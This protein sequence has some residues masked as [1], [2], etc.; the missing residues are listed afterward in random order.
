MDIP[1]EIDDITGVAKAEIVLGYDANF[2]EVQ[3]VSGADLIE[4]LALTAKTDVAGK[5]AI[6]LTGGKG[7]A[8]GSGVM[9]HVTLK[10]AKDAPVGETEIKFEKNTLFDEA[11]KEIPSTGTNGK[12]NVTEYQPPPE[13]PRWDVNQD[14]VVDIADLVLV[15]IHFG[16]DYRNISAIA[17]QG[18]G[19]LSTNPAI[20]VKLEANGKVDA[21]R[22]L[23]VDV[24][25][26]DAIDLYGYQLGLIFDPKALKV[27]GAAP[28]NLLEQ[29]GH[30]T[31]L[32]RRCYWS[33]SGIDNELGH[34]REII[35]VRK[36]VKNGVSASGTLATITFAVKDVSVADSTRLSLV[37]VA[38]ADSSARKVKTIHSEL[39]L[40]WERLLIP[41]KSGLLQ[42]YPNPFNPETW[43]PYCLSQTADVTIR[44]YDLKGQ[45]V[46]AFHIGSRPAGWYVSKT[47]A[48]YWN[49]RNESGEQVASGV[50]FYQLQADTLSDMEKLL[51]VR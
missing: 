24:I 46:R 36:A 31:A 20:H 30:A 14:G 32:R 11:G 38:M 37:N 19:G 8:G 1:V 28:G 21:W 50:Y 17:A 45:L 39:E 22:T 3:D 47:K 7:L 49:G 6:S 29:D 44:I 34:I 48:T 15:G 5:L 16:E 25:A 10:I 13:Y 35:Q 26:E 51:V 12:L 18:D 42:N 4:G 23:Q 43:I 40:H 9:F 41:Q 27:I 2:L 33:M